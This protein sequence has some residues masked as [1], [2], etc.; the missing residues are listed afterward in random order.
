MI[1]LVL[2]DWGGVLTQGEFDR[3]VS[4][5]LAVRSGLPEEDLYRA[6]REGK[7]LRWECGQVELD[8]VW[9]ELASRFA[10]RGTAAEFACLLRDAILPEPVVLDL[11]PVL[12]CRAALAMLS[13]NYPAVSVLVRK[14]VGSLFDRLFFSDETGRAK[15]DPAAYR[16]VLD[17]MEVAPS[18]TLFVDDKERNLAP[19][20]ELGMEVHRFEG[21]I[22]FRAD[23]VARGLLVA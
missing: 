17:A 22:L 23:L 6:W 19:A 21:P 15:P 1:R 13:N 11:L 8:E 10:L 2:L 7:R 4:R 12:R 16:A 3:Q 20:R 18:E 14:S 5:E 9:D